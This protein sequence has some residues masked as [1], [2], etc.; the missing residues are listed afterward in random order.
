MLAP[1]RVERFLETTSASAGGQRPG[2]SA[3]SAWTGHLQARLLVLCTAWRLQVTGHEI[4][5]MRESQRRGVDSCCW[6]LAVGLM[7][8]GF[9]DFCLSGYIAGVCPGSGAVRC[10]AMRGGCDAV[11]HD[12]VEVITT[13]V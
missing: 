9:L 6:L 13:C 11:R 8:S 10:D 2:W 7:W 1:D 3:W 12:A 5:M 4:G